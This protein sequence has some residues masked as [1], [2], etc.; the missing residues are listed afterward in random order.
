MYNY[1]TAVDGL[2][3]RWWKMIGVWIATK[4]LLFLKKFRCHG[5]SEVKV[6]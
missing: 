5:R 6:R 3:S 2:D 1:D 4:N